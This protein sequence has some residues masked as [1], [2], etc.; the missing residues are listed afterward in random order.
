MHT[1]L[2]TLK[3]DTGQD[4]KSTKAQKDKFTELPRTNGHKNKRANVLKDKRKKD[5]GTNKNAKMLKL[6]CG[7]G[8]GR[9][10]ANQMKSKLV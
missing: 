4:D 3:K 6:T 7:R 9:T 1:K 5:R 8:D 2:C 10:R